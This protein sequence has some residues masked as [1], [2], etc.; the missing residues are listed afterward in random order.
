MDNGPNDQREDRREESLPAGPRKSTVRQA[1]PVYP[2]D[3]EEKKKTGQS[4]EQDA[5][6]NEDA[7]HEHTRKGTN[8]T[9]KVH[10]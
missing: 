10:R 1:S 9:M 5:G 3:G 4:V 6:G 7:G 8:S 2:T